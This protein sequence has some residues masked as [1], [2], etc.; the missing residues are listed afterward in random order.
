MGAPVAI[1]MGSQSDWPTMKC[2]SEILDELDRGGDGVPAREGDGVGS[3]RGQH[4]EVGLHP[5]P[6]PGG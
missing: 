3:R 5:P 2:A 6:T 1:V 4:P